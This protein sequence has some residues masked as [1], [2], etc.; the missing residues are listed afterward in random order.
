MFGAIAGAAVWLLL[1]VIGVPEILGIGTDAGLIPFT[2]LGALAGLTRFRY[3]F[4]VIALALLIL[5]LVV[6]YTT[7]IVAP[8]R[9]MIRSDSI[10]STADAVV[11]L[12]A[13][14]TA[15]GFMTQQ[16][17]DRALKA[18]ELVEKGVAPALLFTREEK[19]G[20][21]FLLTASEDQARLAQLAGLKSILSTRRVRSTRD[22][23]LAT[24]SVAKYRGWKHVVVVTSPLHS[25]RACAAFEK[26][27]LEVTCVPSD[28]RDVALRRLAHAHDRIG[29]FA[30]WLYETAGTLRYRQ[31]GWI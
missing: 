25:R 29:A 2:V 15:D 28:S 19:K 10:T 7:L 16:G 3:V 12:S 1:D 26:V 14:V 13:G 27:G 5:T 22:E 20:P 17:A 24:A 23:A 18:V 4:P 9:A 8:A 6:S 11:A 21:A 31:A 30:L